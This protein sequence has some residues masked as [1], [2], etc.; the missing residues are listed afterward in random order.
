MRLSAPKR[1][2]QLIEV[3]IGLFAQQG[4][5]GTTTRQIADRAGVTEAIIYRHFPTKEDLYWAVLEE[6]CR[7]RQEMR[8][9]EAPD[10]KNLSDEQIFSTVAEGI[11]RR[12]IQDPT[13]TRLLFFSALES[14]G[15]AARFYKTFTAPYFDEMAA[16]IRQRI[17]SGRF[18]D[19]DAGLA[20]RTFIG[21]VFYFYQT[22]HL[23]L[24]E[25]TPSYDVKKV[26][27]S[28]AKMWLQG[29]S[30]EGSSNGSS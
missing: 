14:H 26:A 4:Y 16:R 15:L 25:E 5:R 8:K 28:I 18:R 29:V 19:V 2:K 11:L 20:A 3:A 22:Q 6:Q 17:E 12:N 23:F 30:A 9:S 24:G 21:M 13:L 7:A 1:R 10:D 27:R